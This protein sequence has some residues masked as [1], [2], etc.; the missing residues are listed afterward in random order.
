MALTLH[1]CSNRPRKN[2]ER[3]RFCEERPFQGRVKYIESM[4][5]SAPV[6][7]FE[8]VNGV[9]RNPA[10]DESRISS[11]RTCRRLKDLPTVL[12]VGGR[13]S[14]FAIS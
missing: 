8:R 4:R 9:F 1:L 2:S 3:S 5:A 11:Y 13:L 12:E 14:E 10:K 7:V 6:V